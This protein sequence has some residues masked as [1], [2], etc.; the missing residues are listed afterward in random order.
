[1]VIDRRRLHGVSE[2]VSPVRI[3]S[4]N[5]R[6]E[7]LSPAEG[8]QMLDSQARRLLAMSGEEFE[9]AYRNGILKNKDDSRVIRVAALLPFAD[10]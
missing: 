8:K 5:K 6:F 7:T 1:M 9:R 2:E 4:D 3:V 10:E